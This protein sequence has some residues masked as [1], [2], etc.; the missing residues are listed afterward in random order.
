MRK[1]LLISLDLIGFCCVLAA[2]VLR[3]AQGKS[4]PLGI[5]FVTLGSILV[6]TSTALLFGTMRRKKRKTEKLCD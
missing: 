1:K 5:S 6:L 3:V 2:I 4:L